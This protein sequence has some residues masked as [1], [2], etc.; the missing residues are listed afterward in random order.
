ME[1]C[2]NNNIS[3]YWLPEVEQRA[4]TTKHKGDND[5]KGEQLQAPRRPHTWRLVCWLLN[6][7]DIIKK[8]QQ[9]FH[10]LWRLRANV[11]QQL[12][13]NF[14]SLTVKSI[15]NG[16][17]WKVHSANALEMVVK[18]SPRL[19]SHPFRA[20]TARDVWKNPAAS[21]LTPNTPATSCFNLY[22]LERGTRTS[23]PWPLDSRAVFTHKLLN[24][25]QKQNFRL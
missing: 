24:W 1:R 3:D 16:L 5:G 18:T 6:T 19:P 7:T 15:L 12:L 9:H 2:T 8:A 11:L 4:H 20:F 13:C 25:S 17:V 23:K 14:Q 22:H 21:P 10:F